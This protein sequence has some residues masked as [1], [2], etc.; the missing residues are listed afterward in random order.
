MDSNPRSPSTLLSKLLQHDPFDD[1]FFRSTPFSSF[2]DSPFSA[3]QAKQENLRIEEVPV[4]GSSSRRRA[5]SPIIEHPDDDV[6]LDSWNQRRWMQMPN[7]ANHEGAYTF[8][9][10][11]VCYDGPKG[12]YYAAT[13]TRRGGPQGVVEERFEEQDSTKNKHTKRMSRGLGNKGHSITFQKD[14]KTGKVDENEILHNLAE[15]EAHNF[16]R[17]WEQEAEKFLPGWKNDKDILPRKIKGLQ[18]GRSIKSLPS[19]EED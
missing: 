3:P 15:E 1:P 2:F 11:S 13:K 5:P 4:E 18:G 9:S 7:S 14:T 8:S 17:K 10:S 19:P 6:Q 12:A 16:D